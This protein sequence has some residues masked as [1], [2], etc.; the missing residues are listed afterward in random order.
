M[1][2]IQ[3]PNDVESYLETVY[4]R[5][6]SLNTVNNYRISIQNFQK[7]VQDRYSCTDIELVNKIKDGK[8]DVYK[9]LREFVL[10]LDGLKYRAGSIK[11]KMAAVK[12]YLRHF[13]LKIYSEDF[14]Q[15]VKMPRKVVV[16]E[17][18]VTKEMLL[19]L[20]HNSPPKLQAAILV[21]T[22]SGMRIGEL[23]QI[24]ISD[25][26]FTSNPTKIRIRGEITKN[27]QA[28]ETYITS[29]ATVSLKDYLKR[30]FGWKEGEMNETIRG[31]AIF[32]RTSKV[33]RPV[34]TKAD[35]RSHPYM[36]AVNCFD[37]ALKR[38]LR[39][40]PEL[41]RKNENSRSLIHFHSFRKFF[42]TTVGDAVGRD[43][44]EALMGHGFYMDTYYTL[45]DE[46]K[47]EMYLKAEPFLTISD[48][49]RVE[50]T[51]KDVSARQLD[52][53]KM[54]E[55]FKKYARDQGIEVPELLFGKAT[56]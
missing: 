48:F 25:V 3:K 8:H 27:R 44:A 1:A 2:Q 39:K 9:V 56:S 15:V 14:N 45:S 23:V 32:G 21:D 37:Q 5:S 6:H 38:A 26:D 43:Y 12:G 19:R 30:Y 47:R 24:R 35:R 11:L 50:K 41:N 40:I 51:L 53:E 34:E 42:R 29:E 28:R 7:F 46:K 52:L 13:D 54:M 22:S 20:L 36:T 16:R 55:G 49:T 33:G 17:E 10:Y 18:A 31:K 4:I